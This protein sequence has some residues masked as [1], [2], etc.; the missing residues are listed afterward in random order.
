M[1]NPVKIRVPIFNEESEYVAK[2]IS[3]DFHELWFNFRVMRGPSFGRVLN[4]IRIESTIKAIKEYGKSIS[5][6]S[7]GFTC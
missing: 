5:N 7:T 6:S 1:L 2:V 3:N 4:R